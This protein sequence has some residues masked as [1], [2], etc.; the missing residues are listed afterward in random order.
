ML[1]ELRDEA[2]IVV[3][4]LLLAREHGLALLVVLV[5]QLRERVAQIVRHYRL[6]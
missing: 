4:D 3:P 1:R 6:F 5:E 2:R